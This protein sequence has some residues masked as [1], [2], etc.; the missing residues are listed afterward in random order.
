MKLGILLIAFFLISAPLMGQTG[1]SDAPL[2]KNEVKLIVSDLL[3]GAVTLS[4]ERVLGKHTSVSLAAGYKTKDGLLK[5]PGLATEFIQSNP[6]SYDGLRIIPEFRYYL[7]ER[8]SGMLTGFYFGVYLTSIHYKSE[9][10]GIYTNE[11]GTFPFEYD[12]E[13]NTNSAGLMIGYKLAISKHFNIDFLIAGP[14]A[15]S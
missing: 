10:T 13:T 3:N 1:D 8:T 11:D 7:N 5:F 4:Y 9:F 15:G 12:V 14:G 2:F 6:L